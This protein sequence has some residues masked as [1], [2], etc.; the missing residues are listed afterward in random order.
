MSVV[1]Q[2]IEQRLKL[3]DAVVLYC[4]CTCS[5]MLYIQMY[6]ILCNLDTNCNLFL[7]DNC[8]VLY[9]IHVSSKYVAMTEDI[10]LMG[11]VTS[12]D[13]GQLAQP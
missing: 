3:S 12:P 9:Y 10:A 8:N 5:K 6:V 2:F 1:Q 11:F 7:R 13:S 4:Y